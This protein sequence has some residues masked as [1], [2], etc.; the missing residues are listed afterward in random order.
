[1]MANFSEHSLKQLETC[2]PRLQKLMHEVIKY[3]N[4]SILQGQR[5]EEEQTSDYEAGRSTLKWP[6]S[7]H[8]ASPSLAVDIAPY[9]IDFKNTERYIYIAGIIKGI[10]LQMGVP[11]RWGGDWN[12]DY[13]PANN[14][15]N[16]LGHF[17]LN[18]RYTPNGN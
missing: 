12:M 9:P 17:E 8:N 2:D 15:F 7:K 4:I 14:H 11:I 1:M 6:E 13:N 18:V 5:T 16:D 3:V 10:S